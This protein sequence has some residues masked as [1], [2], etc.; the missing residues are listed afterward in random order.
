[1]N[2]NL[3]KALILTS[4]DCIC[5]L[6]QIIAEIPHRVSND[7]QPMGCDAQLVFGENC[8][9]GIVRRKFSEGDVRGFGKKTFSGGILR[10]KRPGELSEGKVQEEIP[11]FVWG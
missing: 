5:I 9:R 10:G 7:K 6:W 11:G 3:S 8:P 4:L 2:V 1:M